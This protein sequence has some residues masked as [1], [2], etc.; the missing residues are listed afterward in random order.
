MYGSKKS[1]KY[2]NGIFEFL[3]CRIKVHSLDCNT[4]SW[5]CPYCSAILRRIFFSADFVTCVEIECLRILDQVMHSNVLLLKLLKGNHLETLNFSSKLTRTSC[6][7]VAISQTTSALPID[8]S[9]PSYHW[10]LLILFRNISK[11]L[12]NLINRITLTNIWTI[13]MDKRFTI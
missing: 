12:K 10:S 7:E 6:S 5:L 13:I 1:Q 4:L 2:K 9:K 11:F 3:S 8:I